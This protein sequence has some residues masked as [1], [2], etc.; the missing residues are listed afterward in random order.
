M[1]MNSADSE[2][3]P[4]FV[5][6]HQGSDARIISDVVILDAIQESNAKSES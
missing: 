4:E 2:G 5:Y 1:M 3:H 6:Y